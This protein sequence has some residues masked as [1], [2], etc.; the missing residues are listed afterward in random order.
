MKR[1]MCKCGAQALRRKLV[2]GVCECLES[3]EVPGGLQPST[4]PQTSMSLAVHPSQALEANQHLSN[5]GIGSR[6]AHYQ[7]DGR[8]VLESAAAKKKVLKT[9]TT[10]SGGKRIHATDLSAFI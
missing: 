5:H 3:G 8:L 6:E 9:K 7:P 10:V 4:W 2:C 1:R